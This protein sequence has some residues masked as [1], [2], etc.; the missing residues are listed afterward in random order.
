MKN[1]LWSILL[2]SLLPLLTQAQTATINISPSS[3]YGGDVLNINIAG[4]NTH[5]QQGSTTALG[6]VNG[7]TV[8]PSA[9]IANSDTD[10]DITFQLPCVACGDYLDIYLYNSIDSTMDLMDVVMVDCNSISL[11]PSSGQTGQTLNVSIA[12]SGTN[13]TQ[14]STVVNFGQGSSTLFQ[15][16]S[17]T[18]TNSNNAQVNVT[19]PYYCGYWPV[20]AT[21]ANGCSVSSSF[22]VNNGN[23][24]S[25][26]PQTAQ[27][28]Q[29]L[30][31]SIAGSGTNFSQGSGTFY[32]SQGSQT[33]YPN[34]INVISSTQADINV[35][36]PSNACATNW[37]VCYTNGSCTDCLYAAIYLDNGNLISASPQTAQAG[38]TL[39]VSIAGSGTNFTQGSGTFY[40]TQGS[41]TIFPNSINPISATQVDVNVSFPS[42][43]CATDWDVCYTNAGCTDCLYA[44]IYLNSNGNNTPEITNVT[45]NT[46]TEGSGNLSITISGN[47]IPFSQGSTTVYLVNNTAG[48]FEMLQPTSTTTNSGSYNLTTPPIGSYDIYIYNYN[49]CGGSIIEYNALTVNAQSPPP[50]CTGLNMNLTVQQDSANNYQLW[51]Q[52]TITG[53]TSSNS[54]TYEWDFGDSSATVVGNTPNHTYATF[55]TYT[56]CVEAMD[57][58]GCVLNACA[59]ITIDSSGNFSRSF[60]INVLEPIIDIQ[61]GVQAI[62]AE[63]ALI[64]MYPNPAFSTT[65]LEID[66]P[67][68]EEASIRVIDLNGRVL[69]NQQVVIQTGIQTIDLEI[70]H[71][72]QGIYFVQY[73]SKSATQNFKLIKR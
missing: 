55:G 35:S 47:N 29:T 53:A 45:P 69:M 57:S 10:L 19:L 62:E 49:I 1:I 31:V 23:L 22:S 58:S 38:Q 41:Q 7:Y 68:S 40:F 54:F 28:G 6:L 34:Y 14:G 18:V 64:K 13:F 44:A 33:I 26:S 32:F 25:V 39:D 36:F 27:V 70:Q 4:T 16:N 17:S 66:A 5:F 11:T 46:V 2:F 65:T 52:P 61:S 60:T 56:I 48:Y 15:T 50:P 42:N 9:V 72:N 37:D 3:A 20:T 51:I 8:P 12:G 71:L 73:Q 43:A 59:T 24:T 63:A 67:A 21:A 30:D